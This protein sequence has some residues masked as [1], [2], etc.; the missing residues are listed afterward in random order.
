[1]LLTAMFTSVTL[2]PTK[3]S[4][5]LMT[6]LRTA[7]A[8]WGMALPYSTLTLIQASRRPDR[9]SVAA[10]PPSAPASA[11]LQIHCL[12]LPSSTPGAKDP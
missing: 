2:R 6:L 7:S 9:M 10:T 1:M 3:L 12:L 11:L 4:T 8:T 5:R